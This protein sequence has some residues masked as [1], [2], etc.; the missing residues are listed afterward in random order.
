[1]KKIFIFPCILFSFSTVTAQI[2]TI[3]KGIVVKLAKE[4]YLHNQGNMEIEGAL[5]SDTLT[6]FIVGNTNKDS[7]ITARPPL[8]LFSLKVAGNTRFSVDSLSI[9]G[10]I[11]LNNGILHFIN[12][13]LNGNILGENEKGY[14]ATGRIKK[15]LNLYSGQKN[16][17]GLGISLTPNNNYENSVVIRDH[18]KQ[19]YRSETSISKY[20]EFQNIDLSAI[21]F[22]YLLAQSSKPA[23]T[24]L[25]YHHSDFNTWESISSQTNPESKH[26]VSVL[27]SPI[28]I[29]RL[30]VFPF[31]ALNYSSYITPN[32][33]GINDF[34]EII[35]IEKC[36]NSKLVVI[37]PR[38]KILH[39]GTDYRN[40]FNGDHLNL[41]A[42]PYYYMFF[43]DKDDSTPIK[44]G[45]FEIIK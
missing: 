18:E 34:F 22:S 11:V 16:I 25:L 38:G 12:I 5:I 1:M 29:S 15:T 21:D 43:C 40:D 4:T 33:D 6:V 36:Q 45:Y 28:T 41:P 30:T 44:K 7:R 27:S 19:S 35:G 37:D 9:L 20:Y 3:D 10:D 32:G 42:G 14:I 2:V 24:F 26:V 39:T 13:R 31:P 17:T 23:E 8:Q